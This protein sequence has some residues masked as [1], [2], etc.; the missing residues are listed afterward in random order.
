MVTVI[1]DEEYDVFLQG[2]RRH[3]LP[4]GTLHGRGFLRVA[5]VYHTYKQLP[6]WYSI[7]SISK[8]AETPTMT[9]TMTIPAQ[10]AV[11]W[12]LWLRSAWETF[13]HRTLAPRWETAGRCSYILGRKKIMTIQ[14]CV[15]TPGVCDKADGSWVRMR[16]IR[17]HLRNQGDAFH[18]WGAVRSLSIN[19]LAIATF[20]SELFYTSKESS[21]QIATLPIPKSIYHEQS[22]SK[23]KM[24][25]PQVGILI[26]G[27]VAGPTVGSFPSCLT[28]CKES[29]FA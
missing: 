21:C 3:P 14:W 23:T 27:V 11:A 26:T 29:L 24:L 7:Y 19:L 28:H 15:L 17:P 16:G 4:T 1:G 5:Q 18:A 12:T 13:C 6:S 9:L 25:N 22:E 20:L 8:T 10:S 2:S